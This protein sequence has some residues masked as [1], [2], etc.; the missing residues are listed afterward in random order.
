MLAGHTHGG[1][2]ITFTKLSPIRPVLDHSMLEG[3]HYWDKSRYIH[4]TLN[5]TSM[6]L[7]ES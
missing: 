4:V 3:L 2:S 5:K 6:D 1:Q 7:L